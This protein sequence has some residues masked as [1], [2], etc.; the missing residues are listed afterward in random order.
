MEVREC[1]C[2]CGNLLNVKDKR[3]RPRSYIWG[4]N[5]KGKS[6]WWRIKSEVKVRTYHERARKQL[7]PSKCTINNLDC[8]G[9]IDV[10]HLDGDYKNNDPSN[11]ISLCRS[12]HFLM[13]K[14]HWTFK[15]LLETK[16]EYS[17]SSGKRRYKNVGGSGE[18]C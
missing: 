11:L 17:I 13:D 1:A 7:K 6:S 15:Q 10:A 9:R 5:H 12:H 16:L 18:I 14:R 3:G 4:H 2:G 8:L